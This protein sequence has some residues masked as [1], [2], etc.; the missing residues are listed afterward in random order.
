MATKNFKHLQ[1]ALAEKPDYDKRR[2]L[3]STL[4]LRRSVLTIGLWP[5]SARLD[6]AWVRCGDYDPDGVAPDGTV[7][8]LREDGDA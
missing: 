8:V 6:Q 1:A 2:L 7:E 5:R 4:S 3:R